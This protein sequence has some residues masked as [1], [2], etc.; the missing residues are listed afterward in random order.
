VAEPLAP[1]ALVA[2]TATLG[3]CIAKTCTTCG[4]E[5]TRAEFLALPPP[6]HGA[7]Q[8]VDAAN[9]LH[10][11]DCIGDRPA[12][13][14]Y[15]AT[16]RAFGPTHC[17]STLAI[18]GTYD[19]AKVRELGADLYRALAGIL[20]ASLDESMAELADRLIESAELLKRC[21]EVTS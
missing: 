11:R 12:D 17:G 3:R 8:E 20:T 2:F 18:E 9:W 4:A 6:A 7:V 10:L 19:D 15:P 21:R 14:R 1:A 16:R 5:Y 13:P